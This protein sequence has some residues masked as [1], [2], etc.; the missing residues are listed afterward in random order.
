MLAPESRIN[1]GVFAEHMD[2]KNL[3]SIV[4][5]RISEYQDSQKD[6]WLEDWFVPTM[7]KIQVREISWEELIGVVNR[8]DPDAG[9]QIQSF[10][11][12]CLEFNQYVSNR[13]G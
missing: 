3:H 13:F 12:K 1:E 9:V 4:S 2:P 8:L 6:K 5:R 7:E 11:E 10:Y